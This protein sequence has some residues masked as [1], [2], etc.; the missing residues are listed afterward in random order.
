MTQLSDSDRNDADQ[1]GDALSEFDIEVDAILAQ[2]D[3]PP[4]GEE[5]AGGENDDPGDVSSE[6][7]AQPGSDEE[8]RKDQAAGGD[9]PPAG[10]PSTD[11]WADAPPALKAA[12]EAALKDLQTKNNRLIGQVS[13]SDRELARLRRES[14]AKPGTQ[15]GDQGGSQEGDPF[16]SDEVKRF[17][18]EYGEIAD[19]VLNLLKAQSEKIARLEAPVAEVAQQRATEA[20]Q[21]QIEV[22]TTAHPDWET[23]VNDKRYPEWLA[24]QPK[25]VQDAAARAVNVEDGQEA[26]W[27]LGQFK[28]HL[29]ASAQPAP[30]AEEP[31]PGQQQQPAPDPKRARQLAAG[32]D[33]GQSAPP[34]QTGIPDDA[35]AAVDAIIASRQRQANRQGQ[36]S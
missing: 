12:H 16:D 32:R 30:A 22:F 7:D 36:F 8:A 11:I 34:V 23:Y 20:G 6:A 1:G 2:E 21:R 9:T 26:A 35:D 27:L 19:P 10:S 17:R 33:G 14:A 31:K 15:Q 24:T 29:G 13:A 28:A 3:E 25:A 5:A 18:E 4:A